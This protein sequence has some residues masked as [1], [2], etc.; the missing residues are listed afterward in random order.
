MIFGG[1]G[2]YQRGD[3]G[4]GV[5]ALQANLT[6]LGFDTGELDGAYGPLTMAA[7]RNFQAARNIEITGVADEG[8]LI[9]LSQA[10]ATKGIPPM[11]PSYRPPTSGTKPST[12]RAPYPFGPAT[13]TTV[14]QAGLGNVGKAVAGLAIGIAAY[15]I[16]SGR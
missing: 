13:T 12:S 11:D 4:D 16:L 8:T 7:V 14:K 9:A 1:F 3:T 2:D 15:K 5:W 10:L 6:N